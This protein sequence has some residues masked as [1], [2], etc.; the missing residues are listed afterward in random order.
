MSENERPDTR[1]GMRCFEQSPPHDCI[2]TGAHET[3]RTAGGETWGIVPPV[4]AQA[5]AIGGKRARLRH[6]KDCDDDFC[7]PDCDDPNAPPQA[8]ADDAERQLEV[9]LARIERGAKV[10]ATILKA[11]C[12]EAYEHGWRTPEQREE[13]DTLLTAYGAGAPAVPEAVQTALPLVKRWHEI[14]DSTEQMREKSL[15][16]ADVATVYRACATDLQVALSKGSAFH[17]NEAADAGT[18]R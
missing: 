17:A 18:K 6:S 7:A 2:I 5:P 12:V 8:P 13:L 4:A 16:R 15:S 3:H 11:L 9:R 14:A 10:T 1:N